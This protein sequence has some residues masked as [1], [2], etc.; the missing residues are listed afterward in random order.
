MFCNLTIFQALT[1]KEEAVVPTCNLSETVHNKWLQ[2]SSGKMIDVYHAMVNDFTQA[3]LQSLYYFNYL[4]GGAARTGPSKTELQLCLAARTGNS[5]RM[6][7]LLDHVAIEVGLNTRVLHLEGE[8]I[9]DS[10]KHKLD[11][12]T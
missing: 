10:A 6:V 12:T 2:A 1:F 5:K 9:F 8:T 4:H 3:A 7:K 11:F